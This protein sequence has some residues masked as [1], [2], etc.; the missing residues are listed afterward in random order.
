MIGLS[1][2]RARHRRAFRTYLPC[3]FDDISAV[4]CVCSPS[5]HCGRITFHWSSVR[6]TLEGVVS[7][8]GTEAKV[9]LSTIRISYIIQVG[10]A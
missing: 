9:L 3:Q 10:V 1:S 6:V 5:E 8:F 4:R 2:L 7:T